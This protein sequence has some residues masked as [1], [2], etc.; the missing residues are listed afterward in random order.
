M[1]SKTLFNNIQKE[2]ILHFTN[3]YVNK[4]N[5]VCNT[6]LPEKANTYISSTDETLEKDS[7]ENCIFD[8]RSIKDIKNDIINSLTFVIEKFLDINVLNILE[9]DV[10]LINTI[11][12]NKSYI[13][14]TSEENTNFSNIRNKIYIE[15]ENSITN[16]NIFKLIQI[17]K[18]KFITSNHAL[19][20]I[21]EDL[22]INT[23]NKIINTF[24]NLQSNFL[25]TDNKIEKTF[26]QKIII[27][28]SI[29]VILIIIIILFFKIK[30]RQPTSEQQYMQQ[31]IAPEQQYQQ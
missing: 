4:T 13:K 28:I 16:D 26:F 31:N 14:Y 25:N 5:I 27:I 18:K 23:I 24:V 8:N 21:K 7:S 10:T 11:G 19:L 17:I 22:I 29:C 2:M 20:F 30:T 9:Q 1:N 12:N 6:N 3:R 15:I